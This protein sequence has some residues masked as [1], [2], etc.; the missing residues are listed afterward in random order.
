MK[1]L[2][3]RRDYERLAKRPVAWRVKDYAD[4]WIIFQDEKAARD[5]AE[6]TGALM[7]GL[8]VRDGN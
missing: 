1:E 5:E 6:K 4:S 3:E 2:P 8:Y 7:Q